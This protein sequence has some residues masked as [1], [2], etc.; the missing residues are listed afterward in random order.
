M[1]NVELTGL[2]VAGLVAVL[3]FGIARYVVRRITQARTEKQA[4]QAKAQESRQVRRANERRK[5]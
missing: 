4:A 5:K 1:D 3:S 2:V